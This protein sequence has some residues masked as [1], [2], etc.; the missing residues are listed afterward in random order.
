MQ[1]VVE[2]I[3]IVTAPIE[4]PEETCLTPPVTTSSIFSFSIGTS[5]PK[6]PNQREGELTQKGLAA[7]VYMAHKVMI[8]KKMK[9]IKLAVQI[10]IV[11][12]HFI[13]GLLENKSPI[14]RI[15]HNLQ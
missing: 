3:T 10:A 9:P 6:K 14:V 4:V 13:K 11:C 7:F 8:R 12:Q 5:K 2:E 1:I 15:V